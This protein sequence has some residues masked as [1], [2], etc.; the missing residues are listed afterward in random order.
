MPPKGSRRAAVPGGR[1]R[2]SSPAASRPPA[3]KKK[4][5]APDDSIVVALEQDHVDDMQQVTKKRGVRTEDDATQKIL[6]DHFK[7]WSA[8]HVDVTIRVGQSLRQRLT[9]D[10]K[11][12]MED[13]TFAMGKYY[14]MALREEYGDASPE[15]LIKIEDPDEPEDESLTK[16][17]KKLFIHNRDLEPLSEFTQTCENINPEECGSNVSGHSSGFACL[18]HRECCPH[19]GRPADGAPLGLA[20]S[21]S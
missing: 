4:K 2:Q 21:V 16:C 5:G 11:K 12:W 18:Q 7:A 3:E 15:T 14:Y 6:N 20:S 9:E 13:P 10:R 17:L 8:T 1:K 19:L